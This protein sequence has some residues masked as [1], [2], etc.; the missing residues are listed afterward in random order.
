MST[1]LERAKTGDSAQAVKAFLDAGGSP[2][3]LVQLQ[4]CRHLMDLPLLHNMAFV[5]AHPHAELAES[6]RLLVEA[7]A[8]IN[9]TCSD[10]KG[11]QLTALLCASECQC[12]SVVLDV[13]L[14]AG[15]DPYGRS[16]SRRT[17]AC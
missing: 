16:L 5:N 9:R 4:G 2:V 12:C 3:I 6:V 17:T 10:P 11:D 1:L 8:D 13:R 15:A 7:G 14:R